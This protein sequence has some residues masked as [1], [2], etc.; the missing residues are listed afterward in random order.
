MSHEESS[1]PK[2]SEKLRQNIKVM[3]HCYLMTQLKYPNRIV[4]RDV[5]PYTFNKYAGYLMGEHV[6]GLKGREGRSSCRSVTG[7]GAQLTK[8]MNEGTGMG[9]ALEEAVRDTTVKERGF[10]TPAAL[11]AASIQAEKKCG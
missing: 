10:L 11:T 3:G 1:P 4:W 7:A 2:S 8:K 5:D 6:L 9:A